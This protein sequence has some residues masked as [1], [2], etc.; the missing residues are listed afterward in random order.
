MQT[1]VLGLGRT[2]KTIGLSKVQCPGETIGMKT[3]R[4][5]DEQIAKET[6]I[7]LIKER[8]LSKAASSISQ[9]RG[10]FGSILTVDDQKVSNYLLSLLLYF[11]YLL[12]LFSS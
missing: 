7:K 8:K 12:F 10:I 9:F 2:N 3:D 1:T 4:E 11:K 5:K 6:V